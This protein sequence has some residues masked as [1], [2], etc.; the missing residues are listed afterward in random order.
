MHQSSLGQNG[1]LGSIRNSY[2]QPFEDAPVV[3]MSTLTYE[4]PQVRRFRRGEGLAC[5]PGPFAGLARQ[6]CP[7]EGDASPLCPADLAVVPTSD[8]PPSHGTGASSFSSS[9]CF[10]A[11]DICNATLS[12]LYAGM[13]HSMSRLLGARPSCVITT[14]TFI[15]RNWN[16]RRRYRCKSR[17]NRTGCRGGGHARRSPQER[18]PPCSGPGKDVAVLRDCKNLLDVSGHKTDENIAFKQPVMVPK[19]PRSPLASMMDDDF[20]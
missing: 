19:H 1:P 17:A 20:Y 16:S 4:T 14:K 10:E 2:N 13:L 12:D 6:A 5:D 15:G 7:P 9:Q 3:Q 18:H 11:D 8:S